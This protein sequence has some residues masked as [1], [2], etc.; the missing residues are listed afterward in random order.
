VSQP[1]HSAH[2]DLAV[3]GAGILGLASALASARRGLKVVVIDRDAQ[4]KWGIGVS[5]GCAVGELL[6]AGLVS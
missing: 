6:I 2:F 3:V 5:I 1:L 4:A